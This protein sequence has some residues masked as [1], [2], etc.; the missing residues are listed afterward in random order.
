MQ[1][2]NDEYYAPVIKTVMVPI[3]VHYHDATG[4]IYRFVPPTHEDVEKALKESY[5]TTYKCFVCAESVEHHA[6]KC[7][8]GP[9]TR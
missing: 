6:N 1:A 2:R 3:E 5:R 9:S 4:I 7:P 8:A